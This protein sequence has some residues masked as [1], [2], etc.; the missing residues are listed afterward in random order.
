[1]CRTQAKIDNFTWD[2]D[3]KKMDVTISSAI[4]QSISLVVRRGIQTASTDQ[5]GALADFRAGT[6]SLTLRLAAGSPVTV[7]LETGDGLPS[8]WIAQKN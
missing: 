8:D 2:L 4:D 3:A 6:S 7:H 5:P 1:L